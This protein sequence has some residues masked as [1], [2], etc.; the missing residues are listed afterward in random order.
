MK[1]E[2]ELSMNDLSDIAHGLYLLLKRTLKQEED[3]S[4]CWGN[5]DWQSDRVRKLYRIFADL[6]ITEAKDENG[7]Q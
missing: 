3:V 7:H 4:C 2:L 1:Y 5:V 6:W